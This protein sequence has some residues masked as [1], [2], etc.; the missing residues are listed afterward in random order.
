MIR[1]AVQHRASLIE[2]KTKNARTTK[3]NMA[4]QADIDE[5]KGRA[6]LLAARYNDNYDRITKLRGV[7]YDA[8]KDDGGGAR[9][10]PI[11]QDKDLAIVNTVVARTLGDSKKSGS[12]IWS[13]FEMSE[14]S[15]SRA[16][17]TKNQKT[18]TPGETNLRCWVIATDLEFNS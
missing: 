17:R 10:R 8:R 4:A 9:L 13:V 18:S 5:A 15:G 16:S 12:W 6:Q 2:H 14:A 1:L 7:N 3:T 11:D